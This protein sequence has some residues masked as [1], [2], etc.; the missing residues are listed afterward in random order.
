MAS[1]FI[2]GTKNTP[3]VT[4]DTVK[5]SLSFFGRS[6]PENTRNFYNPILNWVKQYSP[7]EDSQIVVDIKFTYVNT[8]SIIALLG[9]LKELKIQQERNCTVS[10]TWHYEKDDD[11]MVTIGED[12]GSLCGLGF[13]LEEYE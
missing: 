2:E 12:I 8:S 1:F 13:K 7:E 3:K 6:M 10:V 5:H 4:F 9:I 11:D